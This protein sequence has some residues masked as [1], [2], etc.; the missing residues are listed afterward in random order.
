MPA[1]IYS[2][3]NGTLAG[4]L[5]NEI[6]I[7][8]S[9]AGSR[10]SK[11]TRYR[12]HYSIAWDSSNNPHV[13]FHDPEQRNLR[14]HYF[15][16][17]DKNIYEAE[18][19]F[20][21]SGYEN[22]AFADGDAIWAIHY[23][24]RDPF[25]KGL[26]VTKL[27]STGKILNQ[28][29]L[30][31]SQQRN[32]GWELRGARA[33]N[34]KILVTYLTDSDNKQ[35]VY[36]LLN[37]AQELTVMGDNLAAFGHVGGADKLGHLSTVE[38]QELGRELADSYRKELKSYALSVGVGAQY[39]FWHMEAER[40]LDY[41]IDNA[42]VNLVEFQGKLYNTDYG[43]KY[44]EEV[45]ESNAAQA[46]GG[47]DVVEYI[48]AYV[49]WER[50]LYNYDFKLSFEQSKTSVKL[51]DNTDNTNINYDMDYVGVKLSLLT[52]QRTQFGLVYQRFN[53]YR[54]I[55]RYTYNTGPGWQFNSEGLGELEA[56]I[57]AFHYGYT[58]INYLEKYGVSENR[59]Y[60]D[61]EAR[62]GLVTYNFKGPTI[63]PWGET[64][65]LDPSIMLGGQIEAGWIWFRRWKSLWNLGGYVKLGYRV[66]FDYFPDEEPG[67]NTEGSDGEIKYVLD[68]AS[69]LRHGPLVMV[70]VTF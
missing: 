12:G 21:E 70:A 36:M 48:G 43:V 28:F 30:D 55:G 65:N 6:A 69:M 64:P 10:Q 25:N 24:Y 57:Y 44:A 13:F 68:D 61:L 26:L 66:N 11:S 35:R 17:S 59:A 62:G 54:K 67:E 1:V 23:F 15:N 46:D 47:K 31:A 8:Y 51:T 39:A 27:D 20:S 7:N 29:V 42:I 41:D 14:H 49:G 22:I 9:S 52:Q 33:S 38:Q 37:N 5:D 3:S 60:F 50:L 53:Q 19:D 34:G 32:V 4:V 58:T 56:E 2:K 16:R 63:A 18:V 45:V 40:E